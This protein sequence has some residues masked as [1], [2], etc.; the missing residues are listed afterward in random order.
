MSRE[1]SQ[2]GR[3]AGDVTRQFVGCVTAGSA[4]PV[5]PKAYLIDKPGLIIDRLE[6]PGAVAKSLSVTR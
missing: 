3:I 6:K 2:I 4:S 1:G 5:G